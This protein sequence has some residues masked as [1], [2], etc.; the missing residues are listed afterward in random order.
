MDNQGRHVG[1]ENEYGFCSN[2]CSI[3]DETAGRGC[4]TIGGPNTNANC[5][6]PFTWQGQTYHGCPVD[7]DDPSKRWCSTQIDNL[8]HHVTGK[9]QYGF[10]SKECSI[11]IG[12][13]SSRGCQAGQT[14][15]PI[16]A[17]ASQVAKA[18]ANL[19]CKL[20]GS[21]NVGICC[22]DVR[23]NAGQSRRLLQPRTGSRNALD[24][25]SA[26]Q[27]MVQKAGG[28]GQKISNNVTNLLNGGQLQRLTRGSSAFQHFR[29]QNQRQGVAKVNRMAI[30]ATMTA[31]ALETAICE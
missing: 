24:F 8:G 16:A 26:S 20:G 21:D 11:H 10:C 22:Q 9:N 6:L 23:S 13:T 4:R 2:E 30:T 28:F 19:Q 1:N 5:V 25:S 18:F 14:C 29:N 17:C 7:P 27:F 31:A 3:L 12:Q 15:R